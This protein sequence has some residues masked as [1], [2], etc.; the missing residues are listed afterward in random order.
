MDGPEKSLGMT[1][2]LAR[3]S[4]RMLQRDA[5]TELKVSQPTLSMWENGLSKP[6]V[7]QLA[8]LA[9]LY[10]LGFDMLAGTLIQPPEEVAS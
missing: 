2:R 1:I 6:S 8:R 7:D 10:D 3:T 9:R 5:A 4:R